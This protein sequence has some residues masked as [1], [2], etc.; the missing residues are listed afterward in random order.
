[1]TVLVT[2][3]FN[4]KSQIL[5]PRPQRLS[6]RALELRDN[7]NP[8]PKFNMNGVY[9]NECI[10]WA[11]SCLSMHFAFKYS[12]V[13]TCGWK[14]QLRLCFSIHSILVDT[15]VILW[16]NEYILFSIPLSYYLH[17]HGKT[18]MTL[19]WWLVTDGCGLWR[20][21]FQVGRISGSE[22]VHTDTSNRVRAPRE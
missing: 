21:S 16:I 20:G 12:P 9:D 22:Q 18:L 14:Q 5:R 10:T 1:M 6:R 3:K 15:Y 13:T 8:P 11:V 2:L 19:A 17:V 4:K 7:A